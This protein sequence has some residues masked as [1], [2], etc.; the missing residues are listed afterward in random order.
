ML[1]ELNVHWPT[2]LSKHVNQLENDLS[3]H[4]IA[5]IMYQKYSLLILH[6]YCRC[7]VIPAMK[8]LKATLET[9]PR[10]LGAMKVNPAI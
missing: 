6:M 9:S 5:Y 1:N 4:S 7:S 2:C 3:V 8:A 10:R